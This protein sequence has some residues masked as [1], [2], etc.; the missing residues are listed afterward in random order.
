[1]MPENFSDT[2]WAAIFISPRMGVTYMPVTVLPA[3]YCLQRFGRW[4]RVE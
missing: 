2:R 3:Y 4:Q 1:M